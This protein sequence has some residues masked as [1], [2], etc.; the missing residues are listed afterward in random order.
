MT[1]ELRI[2]ALAQAVGADVKALK[3]TDGTLSGLST[4]E[5][6]NLVAAINEV[7]TMAQ[8]AGVQINDAAPA[9][10]TTVAYSPQKIT[11]LITTA[12][13]NVLGGASAAYDTF[14][15]LQNILE[16]DATATAGLVTT[17]AGKVTFTGTQTL[18]EAQKAFACAN[19]GVGNYDRD[20]LA[21]YVTAKT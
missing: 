13:S 4:I 17:V 20:L 2:L 9:T 12:I 18:T 3:T 21:D 15:E 1:L 19:I 11:S 10:S 16:A 8:S 5:K 6:S 14:I 7:F